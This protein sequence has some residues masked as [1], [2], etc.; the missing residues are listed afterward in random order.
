MLEI[1]QFS[2][3]PLDT[4]YP[5]CIKSCFISII[6]ID[7]IR[8]TYF[9]APTKEIFEI[10]LFLK[11]KYVLFQ[12]FEIFTTFFGT[13]RHFLRISGKIYRQFSVIFV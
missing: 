8:N 7:N 4:L 12:G 5:C 10:G 1:I 6:Y 3:F 13:F 2:G 11:Q 9:S